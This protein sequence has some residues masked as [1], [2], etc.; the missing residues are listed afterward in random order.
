MIPNIDELLKK[1]RK[2]DRDIFTVDMVCFND[3]DGEELY[4]PTVWCTN[5]GELRCRL[6]ARRGKD[7]ETQVSKF[8]TDVGKNKLIG[9]LTQYD[10]ADFEKEEEFHR[11]FRPLLHYLLLLF[12]LVFI[13][14]LPA[15]TPV[16]IP[17][18][19]LL[20]RKRAS[21][22]TEIRNFKDT[23]V[24]KVQVCNLQAFKFTLILFRSS[25]VPSVFLRIQT[26]LPS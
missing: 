19:T 16:H 6:A 9:T 7:V 20:I 13:L 5:P 18:H 26:I 23:S 22:I 17:A 10:L 8:G 25:S 21:N 3:T 11:C 14:L 2:E 12:L 4:R 1:V 24:R 15:H